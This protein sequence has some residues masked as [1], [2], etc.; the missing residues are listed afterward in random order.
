MLRDTAR[1]TMGTHVSS[2]MYSEVAEGARQFQSPGHPYLLY[3]FSRI[4]T[5][6]K[7][8][9]TTTTTA[10]TMA[11]EPTERREAETVNVQTERRQGGRPAVAP[12]ILTGSREAGERAT[13]WDTPR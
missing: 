10:A 2:P 3:I 12:H 1:Y 7:M 9:M 11:P 6:V 13:S 5:T 4:R 8:M